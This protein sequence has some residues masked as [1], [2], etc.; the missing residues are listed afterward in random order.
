MAMDGYSWKLWF[1]F[2]AIVDVKS[3]NDL[4]EQRQPGRKIGGES[5][6]RGVKS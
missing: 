4:L 3:V 2:G 1:Y 6:A 5:R